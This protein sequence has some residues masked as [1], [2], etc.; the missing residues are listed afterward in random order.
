[1][2]GL[3]SVVMPAHN[4]ALLLEMS[5]REVTA[6]IRARS[7]PFELLVVEN[8]SSDATRAIAEALA[9]AIPELRLYTL[10]VADYGVALRTGL[11]V[12]GGEWVAMFDVDYY[13][14]PFLDKALDLLARD[15]G[16]DL[17]IGSKRAPESHDA[18]SP[19]R[20]VVTAGFVA[21]LRLMFGTRVSDTHGM[22]AMRRVPAEAIARVCR[23]GGDLFDTELVLRSER[24]G[25]TVTEL[26]VT[27]TE[28]RPARTPIWRRIPRALWGLVRLRLLLWREGARRP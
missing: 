20:R 26:P 15:D 12:S 18:R 2:K 14:L 21:I 10:P 1:V 28:R 8:G 27:V 19:A 7:R 3:L 13:D 5:V 25:L 22:K 6:G 9:G 23:L 11:L 17:V 24:A 4:E 16:P